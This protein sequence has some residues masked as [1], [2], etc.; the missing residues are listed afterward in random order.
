MPTPN[1]GAPEQRTD[2]N[3]SGENSDPDF[4]GK[5][6]LDEERKA[7]RDAERRAKEAEAQLA[8]VA[9]KDKSGD[10]RAAKA[11]QRAAEAEATR[12]CPWGRGRPLSPVRLGGPN[13]WR[14][15][16]CVH[17]RC[18]IRSAGDGQ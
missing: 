7:R 18:C 2:L 15:P 13:R 1:H 4:K 12:K 17:C 9:D 8:K 3:T 14:R 10:E 11:E 16:S 6:A 5:Q